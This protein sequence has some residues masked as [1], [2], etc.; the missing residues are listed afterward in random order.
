MTAA[1]AAVQPMRSINPTSSRTAWS[2]RT[3]FAPSRD[4][5]NKLSIVELPDD[6]APAGAPRSR[7]QL[8]CNIAAI[9]KVATAATR[10]QLVPMTMTITRAA[11]APGPASWPTSLRV[12]GPAPPVKIAASR[13]VRRHTSRVDRVV[14]QDLADNGAVSAFKRH[15]EK[16]GGHCPREQECDVVSWDRHQ[17]NNQGLQQEANHHQ[18]TSPI[19]IGQARQQV[20]GQQWCQEVPRVRRAGPRCRAGVI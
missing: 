10:A 7:S 8:R 9:T 4:C 15:S 2:S 20:A 11:A 12:T 17:D 1:A 16:C 18:L 13:T 14:G 3:R 19:A 5:T 6:P